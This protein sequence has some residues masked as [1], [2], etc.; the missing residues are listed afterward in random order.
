MSVATNLSA[1]QAADGMARF[2][3]ITQMPQEKIEIWAP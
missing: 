3:N 1:E 2:A